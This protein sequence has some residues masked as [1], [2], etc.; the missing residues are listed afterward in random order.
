M[1][2]CQPFWMELQ[3]ESVT[4]RRLI[5]RMPESCLSWRPHD[6]SM[7]MG[8]LAVHLVALIRWFDSVVHQDDYDVASNALRMED[9]D[10]VSGILKLFD[11]SLALAIEALKNQ[12][13]ERLLDPWRLRLGERLIYEMPRSSAIRSLLNH[14]VH[15]RGQLSVYLRLQNVPLPPIYGPTADETP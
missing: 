1:S 15:H 11:Q 13:D 10:S 8:H 5:E 9:P 6:K 14:L 3:N 2:L 12:P 4:T 7:T